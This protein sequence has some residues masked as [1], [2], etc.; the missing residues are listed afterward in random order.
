[1]ESQCLKLS[2]LNFA[3]VKGFI[4]NRPRPVP[5]PVRSLRWIQ[6]TSSI[7]S[8]PGKSS[9]EAE[10]IFRIVSHICGVQE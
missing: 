9:A 5:G 7:V 4:Q 6:R 8:R 1:M 3:P 2:E 10:F